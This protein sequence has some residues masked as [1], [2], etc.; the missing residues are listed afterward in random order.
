MG[1]VLTRSRVIPFNFTNEE[2]LD[3]IK[4]NLANQSDTDDL[5]TPDLKLQ[6]FTAMRNE[7]EKRTLKGQGSN[8]TGISF[9]EFNMLIGYLWIHLSAK[10]PMSEFWSNFFFPVLKGTLALN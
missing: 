3:I 6:L 5:V 1:A 9:R 7:A 2:V 4:T 8:W 10:R